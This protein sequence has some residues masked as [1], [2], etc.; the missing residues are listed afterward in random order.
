MSSTDYSYFNP[1]NYNSP[2]PQFSDIWNN[3]TIDFSMLPMYSVNNIQFMTYFMVGITAVTLGYVTIKE[4]VFEKPLEEGE[5]EEEPRTT[6][7]KK[8]KS[9]TIRKHKKLK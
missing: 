1:H 3:L 4:E 8:K 6:G 5:R 2:L 7:G 9:K